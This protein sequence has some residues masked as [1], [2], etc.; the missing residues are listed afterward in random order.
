MPTVTEKMR[1]FVEHYIALGGRNATRAAVLAGY[2]EGGAAAIASRLLRDPRVLAYLRHIA[3]TKIRAGVI[4]SVRTL[5]GIRDDATVSAG[6]RRKAASE[7]LDRAGMLIER[8]TTITHE[9]VIRDQHVGSSLAAT[10]RELIAQGG[11][12][13]TITDPAQFGLWAA[14]VDRLG[15]AGV[16]GA[17]S[18]DRIVDA[19][20]EE[21]PSPDPLPVPEPVPEGAEGLE[22][23]LA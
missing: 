11:T 20:F 7:L 15:A 5:E 12:G 13:L 14:D 3:S 6:E 8:I 1:G 17:R 21:L 2:A 10:I 4:E 18:S 19:D 23:L 22:D 9:H 16:V